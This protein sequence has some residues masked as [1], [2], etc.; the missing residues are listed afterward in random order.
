MIYV[1]FKEDGSQKNLSSTE[2]G[3]IFSCRN[4]SRNSICQAGCTGK[5]NCL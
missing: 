2:K 3:W 1:S 5:Y 4:E